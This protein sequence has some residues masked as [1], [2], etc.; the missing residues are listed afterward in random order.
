MVNIYNCTQNSATGF[1]LYYLIYGRQPCLPVDATLALA[2]HTSKAPNTS[3]FVQ[4]VKEHAKWAQKKAE[5]FQAKE[6]Q[7]HKWNY[8]K[9]SKAAALE[10]GDTV[11]VHITA[12]KDCYKIQD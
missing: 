6:A 7:H 11:L 3:K 9:R 5:T 1:S 12:F 8:N 4:K 10:V 2:S